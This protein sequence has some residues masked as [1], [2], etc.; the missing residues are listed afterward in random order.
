MSIIDGK[1]VAEDVFATVKNAAAELAASEVHDR[2]ENRKAEEC[3]FHPVQ[4]TLP[5]D[6]ITQAELVAH[7]RT[8]DLPALVNEAD[9]VV[10]AVGRAQIVRG[11]W[12]K[13]GATV[14]DVGINRVGHRRGA[15]VSHGLLAMSPSRKQ[16]R[17][18][19]LSRPCRVA[20]AL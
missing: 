8:N 11:H 9:I 7:S 6:V 1:Q 14:I 12:I 15:R 19:V 2:S 20:P 13:P 16:K 3:G 5:A 17:P 10:T 18:Q 4:K